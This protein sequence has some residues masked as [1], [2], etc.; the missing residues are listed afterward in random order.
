MGVFPRVAGRLN[1]RTRTPNGAIL[2]QAG[3]ALVLLV[4]GTF[5]NILTYAGV[6]LSVSSLFVILAVFV[7][8][9]RRPDLPRPFRTPGY[10]LVPLLFLACTLWMTVFACM[11]QPLWSAV[12][13]GTILCGIPVYY[14][15]QAITGSPDR[16]SPGETDR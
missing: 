13:I 14:V 10:P 9:V 15:W 7:L 3:C 8:R 12:S 11:S 2:A 16:R 1:P 5:E 4:S 6:G